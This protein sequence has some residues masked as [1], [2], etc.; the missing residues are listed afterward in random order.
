MG[1][2]VK[3]DDQKMSRKDF[4]HVFASSMGIG[5]LKQPEEVKPEYTDDPPEFMGPVRPVRLKRP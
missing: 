2:S 1:G 3:D 5:Q 4:L